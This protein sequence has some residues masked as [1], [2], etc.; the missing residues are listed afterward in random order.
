MKHFAIPKSSLPTILLPA[1]IPVVI[2]LLALAGYL[3]YQVYKKRLVDRPKSNILSR[4][5]TLPRMPKEFQFRELK[6]ATNNFD[7]KRRLGQGGYG[8]VYRGVLP[9]DSAEVV[10]KW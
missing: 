1:G 10:V 6:K 4:L 2:G 5:R 9:E 7:E 3:G 8:V